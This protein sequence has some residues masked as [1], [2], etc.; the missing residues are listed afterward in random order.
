M[1]SPYRLLRFERQGHHVLCVPWPQLLACQ[2]SSAGD[3]DQIEFRLSIGAIRVVGRGLERVWSH[4]VSHQ[5]AT[6]AEGP[7]PHGGVIRAIELDLRDE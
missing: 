2:W 5:E 7:Y 3:E 4:V 6:F 1:N